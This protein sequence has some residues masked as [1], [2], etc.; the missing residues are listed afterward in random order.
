MA[1]GPWDA[2]S[3]LQFSTT[4]LPEAFAPLTAVILEAP[5]TSTQNHFPGYF[6]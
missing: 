4:P 3:W 5:L 2:Q 1:E 6:G